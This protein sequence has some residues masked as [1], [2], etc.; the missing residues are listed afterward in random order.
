MKNGMRKAVVI[1]YITIIVG[2]VISLMYT[3]F[4]LSKLGKS[5]YG[6]FSLVNSIV[7]YIY[8]LDLGFGNAVIRYNSKYM[9]EKNEDGR[10]KV[11]GMFL[12]LYLVLALISIVIGTIVYLNLGKMMSKSLSVDEVIKT[13]QMFMVA[14]VNISLSF[15][16]SIFNSIITAHE[17]FVYIKVINLLR[18]IMNPAIMIT[19]LL[20]GYRA[21]GMVVGSTIFNI[22]L[23]LINVIYCF[24]VLHLKIKFGG[25]DKALFKQIFNYSFFVF[26]GAIAY[27]IYW[28]TDQLIIAMF[29]GAAPIAIYAVSSQFNT[30]F[31]SLSNV[32]SSMFLPK[33][34][35]MVT[36]EANKKDL[37]K[38]LTK[39][40]R[41]QYYICSY[42]FVGFVLVGKQF[43]VRWVGD[44]YSYCYLIALVL[45]FPQIFSIIQ[46]LFATMLEA[47]NMHRVKAYIYLSIAIINVLISILLVK[48]YQ[49]MG[50][51]I[52]TAIGMVINAVANNI[53]YKYAIKLDIKYF[54]IQMLK[55]LIP[56]GVTFIIGFFALRIFSLTSYVSILMF[57]ILFT[58]IFFIV[59]W[60]LGF[61][62]YEKKIFISALKMRRFRKQV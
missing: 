6:L 47:M 11:N 8:L 29:V 59:F 32:L 21:F 58:M 27:Q 12:S 62:E 15:P 34:T 37:M 54:W 41:I 24:K 36:V 43:I 45:M 7:A 51:A 9:V 40:G 48:K 17:K 2:N 28:N 30:Y 23:G 31:I 55:L 20:F 56:T 18:T 26:L 14:I 46:S 22:M 49:G 1:T 57:G 10:K 52:G 3:P 16:L 39:V 50:C 33:L 60:L 25:F 44:G 53:Y 38:L 5:E 19:I 13:K 42:I 61:N 4:M 35:K